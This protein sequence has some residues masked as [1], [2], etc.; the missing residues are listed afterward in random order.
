MVLGNDS[1]RLESKHRGR[2]GPGRNDKKQTR[3]LNSTVEWT[4]AGILCDGDQ[5]HVETCIEQMGLEESTTEVTTPVDRSGKDPR[6]ANSLRMKDSESQPLS[7]S[8][9]GTYRG[10]TAKVNHLGQD[11]REIRFATKGLGK[12]VSNPNQGSWLELNR[13]RRYLKG[14][15]R[16]RWLFGYQEQSRVRSSDTNQHRCQCSNRHQQSRRLR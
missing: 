14:N 10:M 9:A 12:E 15:P 11:T 5:R 8:A 2:L 1:K 6:N 13:L 16:Y 4:D 7:A 3:V